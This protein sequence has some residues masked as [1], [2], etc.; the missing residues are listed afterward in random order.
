MT[1]ERVFGG[2]RIAG[3]T[4]A[5]LQEFIARGKAGD[6]V[7]YATPEGKFLSPE[8][9]RRVLAAERKKTIEKMKKKYNLP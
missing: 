8:A 1:Q 9:V 4:T 2:A 6:A 7:V 3:K 5:V